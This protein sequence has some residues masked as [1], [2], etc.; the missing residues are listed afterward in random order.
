MLTSRENRGCILFEFSGKAGFRSIPVRLRI[1]PEQYRETERVEDREQHVGD[2]GREQF[3]R[4]AGQRRHAKPQQDE[5][6]RQRPGADLAHV[7][8]GCGTSAEH[9]R[10]DEDDEKQGRK[11]RPQ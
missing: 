4:T 3:G 5:E 10:D 9:E 1:R 11:V 2:A 6:G 8:I 7:R